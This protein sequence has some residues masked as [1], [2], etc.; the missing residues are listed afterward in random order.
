MVVGDFPDLAPVEF[1]DVADNVFYTT[2]ECTVRGFCNVKYLEPWFG[3]GIGNATPLREALAAIDCGKSMAGYITWK[4]MELHYLPTKRKQ[5]FLQECKP[6][7]EN[8]WETVGAIQ[9]AANPRLEWYM[10]VHKDGY[11]CG[12]VYGHIP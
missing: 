11:T 8:Q 4:T 6:K 12:D 5:R 7:I 1:G 3:H 10:F 2:M 9:E